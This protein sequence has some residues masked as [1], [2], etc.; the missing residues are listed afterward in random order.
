[1]KMNIGEKS[2]GVY[3]LALHARGGAPSIRNIPQLISPHIKDTYQKL[4]F[5]S[6]IIFFLR[7]RLIF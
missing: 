1:M 6:T 7:H 4:E 3:A 5:I 2:L